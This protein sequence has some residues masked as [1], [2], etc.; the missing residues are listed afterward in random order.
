MPSNTN[1]AEL[2]LLLAGTITAIFVL[3][4]YINALRDLIMVK[5]ERV[6]GAIL[7]A[8]RDAIRVAGIFVLMTIALGAI[9]IVQAGRPS[10]IMAQPLRTGDIVIFVSFLSLYLIVL[11]A[12]VSEFF[13]RHHSVRSYK[14]EGETLREAL[15]RASLRRR[16]ADD[17]PC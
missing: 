7:Q 17:P 11:Y 13:S 4:N 10:R 5:Q 8:A 12:A 9:V 6:N 14:R 16:R 3:A 1:E 15:K 2:A